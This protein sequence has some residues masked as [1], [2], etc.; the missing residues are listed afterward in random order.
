MIHHDQPPPAPAVICPTHFPS[1][2]LSCDNNLTWATEQRALSSHVTCKN[3][4]QGGN[5]TSVVAGQV[6]RW[7]GLVTADGAAHC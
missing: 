4:T 3:V 5:V 7:P 6:A 2:Q 1:Q